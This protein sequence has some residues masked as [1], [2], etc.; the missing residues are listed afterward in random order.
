VVWLL[1]STFGILGIVLS[2]HIVTQSQANEEMLAMTNMFQVSVGLLLLSVSAA[3]SLAEERVRGSLDVLLS[4]PLSSRSILA[5]KWWGTFR[6]TAHVL[7]W[8]AIVAGLLVAQSGRWISYLLLL[9]LIL[10]YGAVITSLGLALATFV[11]RLGG[12]VAL[13]VSTY[14]LFSIGWLLYVAL[15]FTT[16]QS[17]LPLV[18]ASPPYGA[19]C[20]TAIISP[21]RGPFISEAGAIR[22]G[23]FV[24]IMVDAG[25]AVLLFMVTLAMFDRCLGR[26][27]EITG[28]TMPYPRKKRTEVLEPDLADW[29]AET[30]GEVSESACH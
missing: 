8:P 21:E 27:S 1:Y 5:G 2:F 23:A 15:F 19:L 12:A 13:C 16:D 17:I 4:T 22:F 25:V 14:V 10:A 20:A 7:V 26:V 18:L 28:R 3:T 29:F 11:S 24:W 30:S 6:Q 9:G